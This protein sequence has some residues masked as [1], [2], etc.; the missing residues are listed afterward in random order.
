MSL[1]AQIAVLGRFIARKNQIK[2]T[3][4]NGCGFLYCLLSYACS[5]APKF[6]SRVTSVRHLASTT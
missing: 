4:M 6:E 2:K 5:L 1:R 3:T